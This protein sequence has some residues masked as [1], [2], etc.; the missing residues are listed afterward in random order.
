MME[1]EIAEARHSAE[2]VEVAVR[3]EAA[4]AAKRPRQSAEEEGP[5]FRGYGVAQGEAVSAR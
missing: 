2:A 3:K 1:R 4:P 5:E